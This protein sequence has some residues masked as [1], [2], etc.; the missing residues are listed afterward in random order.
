M[1]RVSVN[2]DVH[3]TYGNKWRLCFQDCVYHY[4]NGSIEEGFRFI[5]RKPNGNL[6]AARGQARIPSKQELETLL[7][8]ASKDGWYK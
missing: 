2:H 4:D 6:Q 8:M 7:N 5:W 1:A 3:I